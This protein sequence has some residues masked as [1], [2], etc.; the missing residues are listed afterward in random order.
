MSVS[1]CVCE[2]E[3]SATG[4]GEFYRVWCVWVWSWS[5]DNEEDPGTLGAVEPLEKRV[6]CNSFNVSFKFQLSKFELY[7]IQGQ[8]IDFYFTLKQHGLFL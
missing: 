8:A 4:P 5:L 6:T 7:H 1:L 2:A 3:V